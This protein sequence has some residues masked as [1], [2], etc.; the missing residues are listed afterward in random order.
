MGLCRVG[1]SAENQDYLATLRIYGL[2][3]LSGG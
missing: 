2:A 3:K 1:K